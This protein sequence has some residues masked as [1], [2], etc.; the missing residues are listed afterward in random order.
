MDT[1]KVLKCWLPHWVRNEH[2]NYKRG[3]EYQGIDKVKILYRD[4][5]ILCCGIGESLGIREKALQ[6]AKKAGFKIF[7]ASSA[8]RYLLH[9]EIIP[10]IVFVF[11]G[12]DKLYQD[13][14]SVPENI[15]RHTQ[16]IA[17]PCIAP[18]VIEKAEKIFDNVYMFRMSHPTLAYTEVELTELYPN[19]PPILNHG[20]V[21]N[22]MVMVADYFSSDIIF[23]LGFDCCYSSAGLYRC[24]DFNYNKNK[25][26][27]KNRNYQRVRRG[28]WF[29][30]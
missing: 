12:G 6:Y 15:L 8:L 20:N 30:G 25:N 1:Q 22:L 5:K 23:T 14:I 9:L 27:W 17:H 2:K 21:G 19:Y 13:L 26:K 7:V 29:I 24:P 16:F 28:F 10:D 3:I 11:D 4:K 18:G